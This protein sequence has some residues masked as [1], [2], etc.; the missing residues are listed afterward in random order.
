MINKEN[1]LGI[2]ET[3]ILRRKYVDKT[4]NG[5][6]YRRE[7]KE[8]CDLYKDADVVKDLNHHSN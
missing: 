4:I 8:L 6:W 3:K 1:K 7:N 5:I 2:W